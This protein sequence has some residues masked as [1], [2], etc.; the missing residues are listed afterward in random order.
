MMEMKGLDR[1]AEQHIREHQVRQL[2][3][4]EVEA[5]EHAER[6]RSL[7]AQAEILADW[8]QK[9]INQAGPM[10]VLDIVAQDLESFVE[11]F[12]HAPRCE[13]PEP[14]ELRRPVQ[15]S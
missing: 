9:S 1:L 7:A 14:L 12:E 15:V 4:D 6:L 3:I 13:L 2:K 8:R 5:R 10:G 11:L